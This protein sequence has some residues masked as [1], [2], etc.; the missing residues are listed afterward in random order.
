MEGEAYGK[1][2]THPTRVNST[3]ALTI[4]FGLICVREKA[5]KKKKFLNSKIASRKELFAD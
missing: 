3:A 4:E 2:A 5:K 1:A